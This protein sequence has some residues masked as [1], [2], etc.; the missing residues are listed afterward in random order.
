MTKPGVMTTEHGYKIAG[1]RTEVVY[2]WRAE[3]TT[4][5]AN[6]VAVHI[7]RMKKN[8]REEEVEFVHQ[9]QRA[10]DSK[11]PCTRSLSHSSGNKQR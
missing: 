1:K 7:P 6:L 5:K 4:K 3:Q 9:W 2:L 8:N 11:V 10:M